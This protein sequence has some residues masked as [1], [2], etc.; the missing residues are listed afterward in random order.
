[1]KTMSWSRST[2]RR[3][4]RSYFSAEDDYFL[5]DVIKGTD[6]DT[7]V[8]KYPLLPA[9]VIDEHRNITVTTDMIAYHYR[10]FNRHMGERF[11]SVASSV[12]LDDYAKLYKHDPRGGYT[13]LYA[14]DDEL[15]PVEYN[16]SYV[17]PPSQL[18]RVLDGVFDGGDSRTSPP[19]TRSGACPLT[20]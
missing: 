9:D 2:L 14:Y 6:R 13:N 11:K 5:D 20:T 15:S 7:L 18:Q 8:R 12:L 16:V 4:C 10:V 19:R 3:A 17:Y 1:M